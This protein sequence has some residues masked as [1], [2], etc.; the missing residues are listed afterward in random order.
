VERMT[1][2]DICTF[3]RA[4]GRPPA[5]DPAAVFVA[6]EY[7]AKPD[8]T[9]SRKTISAESLRLGPSLTIRV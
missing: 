6:A 7:E 1:V 5:V 4:D 2:F 3:R 8:Y 9:S